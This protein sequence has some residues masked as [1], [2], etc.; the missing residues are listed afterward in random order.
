MHRHEPV[1]RP[2]PLLCRCEIELRRRLPAVAHLVAID[3]N[4]GKLRRASI[5]LFAI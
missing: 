5:S 4:G 2:R 1:F 3:A